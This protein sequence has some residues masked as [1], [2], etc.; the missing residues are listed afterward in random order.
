MVEPSVAFT[1]PPEDL[2]PTGSGGCGWTGAGWRTPAGEPE[3]G[4]GR[5][6]R[7]GGVRVMVMISLLCGCARI[8]RGGEAGQAF[9]DIR[10][11]GRSWTVKATVA[12]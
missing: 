1:L 11:A 7:T 9:G 2:W 6:G 4:S 3:T 12:L 8:R 5:T 10:T